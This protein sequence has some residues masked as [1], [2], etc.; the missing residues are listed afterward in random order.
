MALTR[1]HIRRLR[2]IT[3]VHNRIRAARELL[4]LTQLQL[5]AALGVT[6]PQLSDWER[7]RYG[8]MT[9]SRAQQLATFFGCAIEDIFPARELAVRHG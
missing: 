2:T 5:A 7:G 4:G 1:E 3:G 6:Q 9:L 8:D